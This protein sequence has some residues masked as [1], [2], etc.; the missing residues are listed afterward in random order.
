MRCRS[1]LE[2]SDLV[3]LMYVIDIFQWHE[4]YITFGLSDAAEHCSLAIHILPK[5]GELMCSS[6]K[7][8]FLTT[9]PSHKSPVAVLHA[10]RAIFA[11]LPLLR[12]SMRMMKDIFHL[13]FNSRKHFS[14]LL[15]SLRVEKPCNVS[16]GLCSLIC[17]HCRTMETG[18]ASARQEY[19]GNSNGSRAVSPSSKAISSTRNVS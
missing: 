3:V 13:R 15:T 4:K 8:A 11:I 17:S 18:K 16:M 14:G 5:N 2:A 19:I 12:G 6:C 9:T 7:R 10:F 1:D